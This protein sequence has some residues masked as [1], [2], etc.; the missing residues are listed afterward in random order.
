MNDYFDQFGSALETAAARRAHLGWRARLLSRIRSHTVA[1]VITALVVVTAPAAAV[2]AFAGWFSAGKP[3]VYYPASSQ[4]GLGKTIAG[5]RMLPIRVAD[6]DGG[7]PWGLRLVRTNR[8]DICIQVGR[9]E[10]G[11]LGS[12]G[13]D[14]SWGNDHKFH[15]ISP[16]DGVFDRCGATDAA[17][18]GFVSASMH[19]WVASGFMPTDY[20]NGAAVSYCANWNPIATL[21]QR[22]AEL[23][24]A[25][26]QRANLRRLI[27][28]QAASQVYACPPG[29]GRMIFAGLLG[30]RAKGITYHT[31]A[32]ATRTEATVGG[33]GAYLIVFRETPGNCRDFTGSALGGYAGGCQGIGFSEYP[34]LRAPNAV[35][36]VTYTDGKTC[37][38]QPNP[39]LVAAWKQFGEVMRREHHVTAAEARAQW[40][41]FAAA[42]HLGSER[43]VF[44]ALG[45]Q[46]PLAGWVAG[47]QPTIA[48][49][50][51]ASTVTATVARAKHYCDDGPQGDLDHNQPDMVACDDRIPHGYQRVR[52]AQPG[53]V[54]ITASFIAHRATTTT[55]SWYEW[56]IEN[57]GNTGGGGSR[58]QSNVR[59]GQ[60]AWFTT[61]EPSTRVIPRG[62]YR[63]T[64]SFMPNAGQAGPE[65]G[66]FP[67]RDG[68][69]IVGRFNF[70]LR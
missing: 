8:N 2:G 36:T 46:C 50:D 19:G 33:V 23:P 30:P 49:R 7:P 58:T 31:P 63:G 6:P 56:Q 55:N 4:V 52:W 70:T 37:S 44:R 22:L 32:G 12:L 65:G 41:R 35:T 27:A 54:L 51:V 40:A 69:L 11:E 13:I 1:S 3:D 67:G 24:P 38:D 47:K 61:F 29:S 60:R 18:H 45:P 42:H 20:G 34:A 66:D 14:Y 48:A 5:T 17:G 62:V 43:D 39:A 26:A 25:S 21:K 68:S 57:P 59:A 9:V 53:Q 28:R 10:Y 15:L 16:D 64:V